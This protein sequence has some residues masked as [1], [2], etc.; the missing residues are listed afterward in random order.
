MGGIKRGRDGWYKV[1]G[2]G[3]DGWYKVRGSGRDGW[4]K[5]GEGW[6]V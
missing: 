3:R 2:S 6:V 1:R 5:E 4:Y